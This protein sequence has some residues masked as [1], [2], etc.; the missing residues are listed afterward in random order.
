MYLDDV[1]GHVDLVGSEQVQHVDAGV[2]ARQGQHCDVE[3]NPQLHEVSRPHP[4]NPTK[5]SCNRVRRGDVET[6]SAI[7][8]R[9]F[10][11]N[12]PTMV[13]CT[14]YLPVT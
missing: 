6:S 12:P 7:V 8:V 3:V 11:Q 5:G 14:I 13:L 4:F 10:E 9:T 1:G 2:L